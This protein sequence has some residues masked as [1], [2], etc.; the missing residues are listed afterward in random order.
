[1]I[2]NWVKGWNGGFAIAV[3]PDRKATA[4]LIAKAHNVF[5]ALENLTPGGSEFV[6]DPER[7][8]ECIKQRIDNVVQVAKERNKAQNALRHIIEF[9]HP[10]I[11]R[12]I[13]AIAKE[14]LR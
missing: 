4:E 5:E 12:E 8:L 2:R 13:I 6:D 1:M 9:A 14:A 11:D 10:T 7:C 3:G